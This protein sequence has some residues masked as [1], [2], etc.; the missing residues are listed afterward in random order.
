MYFPVLRTLSFLVRWLLQHMYHCICSY[1][2]NFFSSIPANFPTPNVLASLC[3]LVH[4][5]VVCAAGTL[6]MRAVA[7]TPGAYAE[8]IFLPILGTNTVVLDFSAHNTVALL[9]SNAVVR[10]AVCGGL[11]RRRVQ[12]LRRYVL[13]MA[14]L[15]T[16]VLRTLLR[17]YVR[18]FTLYRRY[19]VAITVPAHK[20]IRRQAYNSLQAFDGAAQYALLHAVHFTKL[21]DRTS[22]L[23]PRSAKCIPLQGGKKSLKITKKTL[24]MWLRS[25]AQGVS[26][27]GGVVGTAPSELHSGRGYEVGKLSKYQPLGTLYTVATTQ[28]S[29]EPTAL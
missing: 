5:N 8:K 22:M 3:S 26:A 2:G 6:H 11:R 13:R 7:S 10:F 29:V 19:Y 14:A 12:V 27:D 23:L 24:F 18:Q 25:L 21:L 20:Y 9:H 28:T 16:A 4:K 1:S 17:M 15:R